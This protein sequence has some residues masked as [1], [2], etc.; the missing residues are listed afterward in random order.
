MADV[1]TNANGTTERN[2]RI[3]IGLPKIV[4]HKDN[5]VNTSSDVASY[6]TR[7]TDRFD[8]QTYYTN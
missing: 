2:N 4:Q 1:T 8:D 7:Y 6:E 3:T 5:G